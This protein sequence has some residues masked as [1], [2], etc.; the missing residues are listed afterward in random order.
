MAW[1]KICHTSDVLENSGSPVKI[2]DEHIAIF[3]YHKQEWY[4]IQNMCPHKK[5]FVLARGLIGQEHEVRKVACP[6]HK[7]TFDL[8]TGQH[9]G[10]KD[11]YTL[12][13]Y[14]IKL[15]DHYL[16]IQI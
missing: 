14:P 5:Q 7:N 1:I 16:Y 13:T 6:M 2:K 12:K 3:N 9:L 4:A 15:E 11:R 8:A 10:G